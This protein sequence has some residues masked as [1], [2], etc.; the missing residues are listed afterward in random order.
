MAISCFLPWTCCGFS[1]WFFS[2]FSG[3]KYLLT[4]FP[5]TPHA[6]WE[7][8]F[9][10]AQCNHRLVCLKL[11]WQ[12]SWGP[13][14]HGFDTLQSRVTS[15]HGNTE[16]YWPFYC[17]CEK[18]T[19]TPVNLTLESCAQ[20]GAKEKKNLIKPQNINYGWRVCV[21]LCV[22]A[23]TTVFFFFFWRQAASNLAI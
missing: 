14:G 5:L 10:T 2:Q 11:E 19:A 4:A 15:C 9:K 21:S 18:P 1:R 20:R 12:A 13:A 16:C 17:W 6:S 8:K 7:M 22:F 3:K 23:L